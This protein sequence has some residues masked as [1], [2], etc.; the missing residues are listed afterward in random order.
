MRQID[1]TGMLVLCSG[2]EWPYD[3]NP[4]SKEAISLLER[5]ERLVTW[6]M[7]AG[8]TI[9]E[10][11]AAIRFRGTLFTLSLRMMKAIYRHVRL[12][13]GFVNVENVNGVLKQRIPELLLKEKIRTQSRFDVSTE[14]SRA[15]FMFCHHV[16]LC[17]FYSCYFYAVIWK[18][19]SVWWT[20]RRLCENFHVWHRLIR[21]TI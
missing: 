7:P 8:G 11:V 17:L 3:M 4:C 6:L 18:L 12:H 15:L 10:Q 19:K 21:R 20:T 14:F 1:S 5:N 9:K 13:K 16:T 2:V